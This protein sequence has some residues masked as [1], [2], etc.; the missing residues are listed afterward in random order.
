MRQ[1]RCEFRLQTMSRSEGVVSVLIAQ[2]ISAVRLAKPRRLFEHGVEHRG[3]VAGRGVDDLQD[4]GGRGL[5]LEPLVTLG[6]ALGK[7]TSQIGY[8]LLGIG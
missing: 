6:L 7:L 5:P 2:E 8:E 3:E 4:L 1:K